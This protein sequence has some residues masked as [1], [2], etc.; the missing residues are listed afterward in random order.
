MTEHERQRQ[1]RVN[2]QHD[3][4]FVTLR[5]HI[6]SR[7]E[8]IEK[9]ISVA[10]DAMGKRL[11]SL[12]EIRTAMQ[13]QQR[14]LMPRS[15]WSVAHDQLREDIA[16]LRE[17]FGRSATRVD[18]E[19]CRERHSA[20]DKRIEDRLNAV[21]LKVGTLVGFLIGSGV[22]GGAIGAALSKVL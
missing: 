6:E 16:G 20:D 3:R 18:M 10:H 11:E 5:D 21:Q 22:L 1:E 9:S 17:Q 15:E 14:L 2:D 7:L 19:S 13:D 12:N 8:S 4:E